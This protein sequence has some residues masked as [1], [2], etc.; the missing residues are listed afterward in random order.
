MA[1]VIEQPT[2]AF[3]LSQ[4]KKGDLVWGKH[5]TWDEGKAGFVTAATKEQLIVQFHPGIGNVTNHFIVPVAE[6]IEGQWQIR[7]SSDMTDVQEYGFEA[8]EE[9]QETEGSEV[10]E[11]ESSGADL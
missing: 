6:A 8:D 2:A 1:L 4:I 7:Y 9:E 5:F 3:D 11:D 10:E